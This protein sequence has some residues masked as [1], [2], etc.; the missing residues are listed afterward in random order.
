MGRFHRTDFDLLPEHAFRPRNGRRGGMTLEGGGGKGGSSAPAPD[1]RLVQA[2]IKSMGIQ[3]SAIQ[4]ML[5]NSNELMP[6]QKQQLQFGL[7]S[8]KT[9]YDQSQSDRQWLLSRR[10]QLTGMQDSLVKEAQA[11]NTDA[12]RE[13]LAGQAMADVNAAAS[14]AREQSARSMARM[15]IT[16]GSG[17]AMA[18][19]SQLQ[20]AQ[21][22]AGAGAS[23]NARTAARNEGRALTDRAVNALAGYPA[24]SSQSATTGAAL[25]GSGVGLTSAS[26]AGQNSG[27]GSAAAVAGQLGTNATSM[28]GAQANYKANSESGGSSFA[29]T[30]GGI[31]SLVGTGMKLWGAFSD[32][33]L[34]TDIVPVGRDA[35]SGVRLYSFRYRGMR[36]RFIGAMVHE[37]QRTHPAAVSFTPDGYGRIDYRMLGFPMIEV[38][39]EQAQ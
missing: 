21:T 37:V 25:G 29:D 15:G 32:A 7:D 28:W 13:E 38:R 39:D 31:G 6:L 9:A 33:R 1:P 30:A 18:M 17:R 14:S 36:Q 27:F 11:F 24:M 20:L 3:D 22:V 23:N 26:L 16:P 34:K 35:A 2:Q 19:D 4:Q 12:R 5:A 8:A 10:D